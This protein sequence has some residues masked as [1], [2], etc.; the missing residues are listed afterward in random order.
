M[1]LP[2]QRRIAC[3]L[4]GTSAL[5]EHGLATQDVRLRTFHTRDRASSRT[6]SIRVRRCRPLGTDPRTTVRSS[7]QADRHQRSEYRARGAVRRADQL[8]ISCPVPMTSDEVPTHVTDIGSSACSTSARTSD[9]LRELSWPSCRN[10]SAVGVP[11][12]ST[13]LTRLEH[14]GSTEAVVVVNRAR[15]AAATMSISVC[16]LLNSGAT[17]VNGADGCE[18][19]GASPSGCAVSSCDEPASS[20]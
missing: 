7:Y 6:R 4:I 18:V 13:M 12:R 17:V 16:S 1:V 5:P 11:Y 2:D 8:G 19:V 10:P 15:E 3:G 20:D 14:R 9:S